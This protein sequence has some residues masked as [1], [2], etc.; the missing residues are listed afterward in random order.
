MLGRKKI[1]DSL[2]ISSAHSGKLVEIDQHKKLMAGREKTELSRAL[3]DRNRWFFVSLVLALG[4]LLTGNGWRIA[5]QRFADNVRVEWVK[6]D[7]SGGYTVE[8]SDSQQPQEYF[9]ATIDA[10]LF[11]FVERRYSKRGETISDDYGFAYI[12]MSPQLQNEFLN[13]YGAA[14]VASEHEGCGQCDEIDNKARVVDHIDEITKGPSMD[15]KT[16]YHSIL[17]ATETN[18]NKNGT[19]VST[20]NVIVNL[21]WRLKTKA[22]ISADKDNLRYNP[23]GIEILRYSKKDDPNTAPISH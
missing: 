10:K 17:Y 7:P 9:Q 3:A 15:K 18:R 19:L 8:F 23:V 5:E 11:E 1:K 14:K 20:K 16:S 13:E 2:S 12:M 4:I 6:L 21:L 22:E